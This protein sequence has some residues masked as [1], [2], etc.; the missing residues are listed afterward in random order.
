MLL[1]DFDFKL[2]Q[3]LIAQFP[4]PRRSA[5]RMLSLD[6]RT[7][8]VIHCDFKD[9][10]NLITSKDLLVFNDTKVISARL[11]AI[12]ITGGKTEILIERI[13]E[14]NK[15][16]AQIKASKSIKA[17]SKLI[18]DNNNWFEIVEHQANNFFE[19]LLHSSKSLNA[20]LEQ[21]GQVPLP[22]Y[23]EHKPTIADKDRYQTIYAKYEGAVAAPTAGLHFDEDLMHSLINKKIQTAFLTLHTGAGTFQPIRTKNIEDHKMHKE[24]INISEILCEQIINTKKNNGRI[25]AVGTTS[26]RAL[27]TAC[28]FGEIKPY[29]GD[30]D[31]FI[32]PGYQFRCID[33]LITNFHLPKSSLLLL[34][35][36]LAGHKNI[37]HAYQEAIQQQYRFFSYGDVMLIQ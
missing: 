22:P 1:E 7:G 33:A 20:V 15:V 9:I 21:F 10:P 37:M 19:L 30:T 27:E 17:G 6:K 36:A 3:E 13:L 2:P 12:K 25:I 5:S 23:I 28:Q 11:F 8:A 32:Y 29:E 16:L 31:I 35:C 26:A 18:L 24:Y 14:N 34:I 4:L